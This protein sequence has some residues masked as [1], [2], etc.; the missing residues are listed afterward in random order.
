[1]PVKWTTPYV[2]RYNRPVTEAQLD[3]MRRAMFLADKKDEELRRNRRATR[4]YLVAIRNMRRVSNGFFNMRKDDPV[5]NYEKRASLDS[6]WHFYGD[7]KEAL[8]NIN[9]R[10]APVRK[11]YGK[12]A[13][14]RRR[15]RIP[16]VR[17]PRKRFSYRSRYVPPRARAVPRRTPGARLAP[18]YQVRTPL[19]D[20]SRLV[21]YDAKYV[22]RAQSSRARRAAYSSRRYG[23]K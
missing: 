4:P 10:G 14:V 16:I 1:M 18:T 20:Y 7:Y 22:G 21:G 15:R 8:H 19:K 12:R 6:F 17:N 5:P 2:R 9:R 23:A 3:S 13:P 11:L